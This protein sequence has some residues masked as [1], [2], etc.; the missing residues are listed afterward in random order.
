MSCAKRWRS[1]AL[2][3]PHKP[4]ICRLLCLRHTACPPLFQCVFEPSDGPGGIGFG[5]NGE[6]L[7]AQS[8]SSL[9]L[10]AQ[11]CSSPTVRSELEGSMFHLFVEAPKS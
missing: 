7:V 8:K 3:L 5:A 9:V 1:M 11:S 2:K 10:T 4:G 6:T